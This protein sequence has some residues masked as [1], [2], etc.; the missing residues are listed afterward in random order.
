MNVYN[1]QYRVLSKSHF[2]CKAVNGKY[3]FSPCKRCQSHTG[4]WRPGDH[5]QQ[6]DYESHL[7]HLP[8]T[9]QSMEL[10]DWVFSDSSFFTNFIHSTVTQTFNSVNCINNIGKNIVIRTKVNISFLK[11]QN[12]KCNLLPCLSYVFTLPW[13]PMNFVVLSLALKWT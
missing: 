2:F 7:C 12:N 4:I 13:T 6:N 1:T 10:F 3:C 8:F 9:L 11:P 5:V